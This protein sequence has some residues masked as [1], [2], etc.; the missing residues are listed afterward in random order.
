M[1]C[2]S[3]ENDDR[4]IPPSEDEL[5][6]SLRH[7]RLFVEFRYAYSRPI[8]V[9]ITKMEK[10]DENAFNFEGITPAKKTVTGNVFYGKLSDED[11]QAELIVS[12]K[13]KT[14]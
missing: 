11:H 13:A 2:D 5:F 9:R 7:E 12:K 6:H 10:T 14:A 8:L 4:C 3:Q 1:G